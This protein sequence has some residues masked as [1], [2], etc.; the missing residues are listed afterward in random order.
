[1]ALFQ[2]D[3]ESV[4]RPYLKLGG[5]YGSGQPNGGRAEL[6]NF[7]V[8]CRDDDKANGPGMDRECKDDNYSRFVFNVYHPDMGKV[9]VMT[10][11]PHRGNSGS[12]LLPWLTNL[13]FPVT[14]AG[15]FDPD[16]IKS[17]LP[18]DCVIEVKGPRQDRN[19]KDVYYSG[20]VIGVYGL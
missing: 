6:V 3:P 1:M 4:N 10:W 9:T 2:I 5:R 19:D 12:K 16:S 7:V 15:E 8:S 13:G 17:S 20:D 11:Q 14:T 18:K